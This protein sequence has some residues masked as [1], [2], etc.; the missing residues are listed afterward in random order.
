MLSS[1]FP[2]TRTQEAFDLA[3]TGAEIKVVVTA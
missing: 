3:A 2:Y 1:R